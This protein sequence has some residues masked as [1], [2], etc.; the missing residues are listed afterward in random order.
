MTTTTRASSW[1][2]QRLLLPHVRPNVDLWRRKYCLTHPVQSRPQTY[3]A[4]EEPIQIFQPRGWGVLLTTSCCLTTYDIRH[5]APTPPL[6]PP[7]AHQPHRKQTSR[8]LST[9]RFKWEGRVGTYLVYAVVVNTM[10]IGYCILYV[11]YYL[12][13]D[14]LRDI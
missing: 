8:P 12:L 10:Y 6:P 5:T 7:S 2:C 9:C 4:E 13:V 11:R 14:V 3:R 1:P